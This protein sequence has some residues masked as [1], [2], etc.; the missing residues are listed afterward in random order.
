MLTRGTNLIRFSI[1]WLK[2]AYYKITIVHYEL[3][4]FVKFIA[5]SYIHLWKIL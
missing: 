5:Q 2:D 4:I 1:T 3:I